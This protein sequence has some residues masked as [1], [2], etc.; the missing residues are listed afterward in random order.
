MKYL[1]VLNYVPCPCDGGEGAVAFGDEA[2]G[3][4]CVGWGTHSTVGHTG[5]C[6]GVGDGTVK[7]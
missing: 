4:I 3:S 7:W 1:L 2:A 5:P 6:E